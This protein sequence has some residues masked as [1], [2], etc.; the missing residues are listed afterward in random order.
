VAEILRE[1]DIPMWQAVQALYLKDKVI[2]A[3]AEADKLG[4]LDSNH[5]YAEAE[6]R[7]KGTQFKLKSSLTVE[8]IESE[9]GHDSKHI[10]DTI[11]QACDG[12]SKRFG[13]DG[14]V[15]ARVSLLPQDVE[16]PWMPGRWGYYIQKEPFGKICL[17]HHL[18]SDLPELAR[19]VRH[20][21]MHHV[22]KNLTNGHIQRWL[23]EA[24]STFAE[25]RLDRQT[26]AEF[27]T[28][29]AEWLPVH[30]LNAIVSTDNR[31]SDRRASIWRGYTQANLVVRFLATMGG[32]LKLTEFLRA[33][34]DESFL[35]NLENQIL[36]RSST[37]AAFRTVYLYSEDE[38]FDLAKAWVLTTPIPTS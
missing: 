28:G 11:F 2:E 12:V 19:T 9:V 36:W 5:L 27:Q 8:M 35:H 30:Q 25:D 26:W 34:G 17:P 38:V 7:S 13:W 10:L 33:I 21:F 37:D 22:S 23:G 15:A 29:K 14:Q 3:L 32:D 24:M 20:E 31:D 16:A 1:L 6:V 4:G 18:I